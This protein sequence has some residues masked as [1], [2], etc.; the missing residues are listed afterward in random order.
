MESTQHKSN[1]I[2]KEERLSNY[3]TIIVN[4]IIVTF[5]LL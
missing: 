2:W 3:K 1:K 4:I 5:D